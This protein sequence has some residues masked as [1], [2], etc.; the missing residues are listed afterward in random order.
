VAWILTTP[1]LL[2]Q[3]KKAVDRSADDGGEALVAIVFSSAVIE[4]FLNEAARL[5]QVHLKVEPATVTPELLAFAEIFCRL[6]EAHAQLDLK[7]QVAGAL[8]G[9]DQWSKGRQ[10]LQDLMLL[11]RL[12]NAILHARPLGF[13]TA[14]DIGL[15]K[16]DTLVSALL[17]RGVIKSVPMLP[18][19][20]NPAP[21]SEEAHAPWLVAVQ[22]KEVAAWALQTALLGI[23]AFAESFPSGTSLRQLLEHHLRSVYGLEWKTAGS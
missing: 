22:S 9:S 10:P 11:S 6:E 23:V 4:A 15:S 12:R 19:I 18:P 5:I 8:L 2:N 1:Q 20:P 16:P 21:S 17:S 13:A 3:A 14:E 7:L